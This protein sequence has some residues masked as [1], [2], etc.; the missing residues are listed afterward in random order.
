MADCSE[1]D[2]ATPT[3]RRGLCARHY[4]AKM[5]SGEIERLRK[6]VGAAL[7]FLAALKECRSDDCIPWPFSL[8][9]KGY[10][11][12]HFRGR[13][14]NAQRIMCVLAHGEAPFRGAHAAHSCGNRVCV[15]P[16]HIY[17]ASV[18]DNNRDKS[19]HGTQTWGG[20]INTARL[21]LDAV[22]ALRVNRRPDA[23]MAKQYG[24]SI[25]AIHR[26]RTGRTWKRA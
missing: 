9:T 22:R 20:D 5:A 11:A 17:W 14:H 26:A 8:N 3:S 24:V 25:H 19:R 18:T 23:E 12:A 2:C 10:G 4:T 6:P 21:T 15:N 1:P 7:S 13:G 16:R